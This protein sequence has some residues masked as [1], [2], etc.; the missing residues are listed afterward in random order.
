M[1]LNSK[2]SGVPRTSKAPFFGT[3]LTFPVLASFGIF[4]PFEWRD[5][6]S[7]TQPPDPPIHS[8]GISTRGRSVEPAPALPLPRKS[9]VDWSHW[10]VLGVSFG[11]S[12]GQVSASKKTRLC[13]PIWGNKLSRPTCRRPQHASHYPRFSLG[14]EL[15]KG[16]RR[17]QDAV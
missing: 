7:P 17:I 5:L 11:S 4:W 6:P 1:G 3:Q 9:S 16:G 15:R 2:C 12:D 14:G 8:H 13:H 10:C